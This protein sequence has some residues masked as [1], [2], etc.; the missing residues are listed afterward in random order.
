MQVDLGRAGQYRLG[1]ASWFLNHL[2]VICS[3]LLLRNRTLN[4]CMLL[5]EIWAIFEFVPTVILN[6]IDV[7]WWTYRKVNMFAIAVT[8]HRPGLAKGVVDLLFMDPVGATA[9]RSRLCGWLLDLELQKV[10]T[11]VL[12][13]WDAHTSS[14]VLNVATLILEQNTILVLQDSAHT[15]NRHVSF[16]VAKINV[17]CGTGNRFL[18]SHTE[19]LIM[20]KREAHKFKTFHLSC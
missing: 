14:F 6:G 4:V 9:F 5:S 11:F 17:K 16:D 13:E 18:K 12:E 20:K 15:E 3:Y 10:D 7:G 2:I 1:H 8:I 19:W